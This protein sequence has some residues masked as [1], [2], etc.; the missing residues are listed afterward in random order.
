MEKLVA[1]LEEDYQRLLALAKSYESLLIKCSEVSG[2]ARQLIEAEYP[3]LV[4]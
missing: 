3:E 4:E 1:V 2:E